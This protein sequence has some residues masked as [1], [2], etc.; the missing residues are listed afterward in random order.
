MNGSSSKTS[1]ASS[2]YKDKEDDAREDALSSSSHSTP[3]RHHRNSSSTHK[4]RSHDHESSGGKRRRRASV[5]PPD[6]SS[7]RSRSRSSSRIRKRRR[8]PLT[9]P[10]VT[11]NRDYDRRSC[12]YRS[13]RDV[14]RDN[15]TSSSRRSQR[16]VRRSPFRMT[17][18]ARR[19]QRRN[20]RRRRSRSS[21]TSS[22][23]SDSSV[24][25][26]KSMNEMRMQSS[27]LGE[28]M[29]RHQDV[30][31]DR[32]KKSSKRH[33]EHSSRKRSHRNRRRTPTPESSEST[34]S[35]SS[36]SPTPYVAT[37]THN[38]P[39][40]PP[41]PVSLANIPPPSSVIPP[42]PTP[43]AVD[44]VSYQSLSAYG[45][46]FT[47]NSQYP[48]S[49][50][51]PPPYA[52]PPPLPPALPEKEPI[53]PPPPLPP[54]PSTMPPTMP[55]NLPASVPPIPIS[56][57]PQP[58][59][60]PFQTAPV[61]LPAQAPPVIMP[62]PPPPLPSIVQH[63]VVSSLPLPKLSVPPPVSTPVQIP[64]PTSSNCATTRKTPQNAPKR[65]FCRPLVLNKR[66]K[67]NEDPENWGC[68]TIEKYN[69]KVQVGEGTYGQVYKAVDKI[70]H[71]VVALK[72]VRL[73]NE[74]EG[75][76]ITAVREIKILR[77]LNHKNVVR[78]ID[79]VTDKQTA[80]DFRKDKGAFYLVFEYLDHDLMGLLDS[81]LVEF[82]D[83]QIASFTKQLI[84]G[85]EYC[86]SV[87]FLHRDIKCSNILLNNKGEIKL[88][89]FGLARLYDEDQDRPY[90]NRVITLWYRPPEL[91]LGEERY[92]TAVDVW[93]VGCIV[94]ELYTR[95]PLFQ[96]NSE[97]AQ[98][99]VISRICGTPSPENWPDV[100]RLPLYP[101]FRPRRTYCRCLRE[102]FAFIKEKALDLLDRML[103]LDPK[104]RITAKSALVHPWLRDVDP[105]KIEPPKLPDWQDCHE[106]W[107]KR[108]RRIRQS[109][110]SAKTFLLQSQS[111]EFSSRT[112]VSLFTV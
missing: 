46:Q 49:S 96:G 43:I 75:F 82:N 58:P 57:I 94:G 59:T 79:I 20:S 112:A 89:D 52:Q 21:S 14:R 36:R 44:A 1:R 104:R 103:E 99:D 101:S 38:V 65:L 73:E 92:T 95:K 102:S 12:D 35:S 22:S 8:S 107:S 33:T 10:A 25:E 56:S 53:I 13:S 24:P 39:P 9:P 48:Y 60:M 51:P 23:S 54:M 77:Q 6:A 26:V 62:Q 19:S 5:T 93:S 91:L 68:S 110:A 31:L 30:R 111:I 41:P 29:N 18:S 105:S 109:T 66:L 11:K 45:T 7:R 27:L 17:S 86:H 83:D 61:L 40:P 84:S 64:V 47:F 106:M 74:K 4:R 71:E 78:L 90:T 100:T 98:L 70:T 32:E 37:S 69:I 85:L 55:S 72:K 87:R 3:P 15:G 34:S 76:P 67:L 50:I 28:I 2:S 80:A 16:R 42:P 97:M 108:Q 88:A 81:Q 63:P